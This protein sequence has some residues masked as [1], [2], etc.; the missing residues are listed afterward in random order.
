M[1]TVTQQNAALVE[2]ATAASHSLRDQAQAL[3]ELV[4]VFQ[5]ESTRAGL[6]AVPATT[7]ALSLAAD[8]AEMLRRRA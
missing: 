3:A 4:A 5:L 2:E 1:D 6:H 7:R 8:A